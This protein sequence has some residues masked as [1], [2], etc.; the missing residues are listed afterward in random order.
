[1][2]Y[3]REIA[4]ES[5]NDILHEVSR[6]SEELAKEVSIGISNSISSIIIVIAGIILLFVITIAIFLWYVSTYTKRH[7]NSIKTVSTSN[8]LF[9]FVFIVIIIV[10]L[11]IALIRYTDRQIS[12][13][14]SRAA[15]IHSN[16]VASEEALDVTAEAL[17]IYFSTPV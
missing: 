16:Y 13:G 12:R 15:A 17:K 10:I 7:Y 6:S 2:S 1:M 4:E 8:I 9:F 5:K 14:T 3:N 11:V